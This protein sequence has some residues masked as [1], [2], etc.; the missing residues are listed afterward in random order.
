MERLFQAINGTNKPIISVL[1]EGRPRVLGTL[2]D[3]S[4]ALLQTYLPGP[5]GGQAIGEILFGLTNPSGKLPYTYPKY[6]GDIN[7]NYWRPVSDVWDPLYEF[8]HGLSYSNFS[9]VSE[10]SLSEDNSTLLIPGNVGKEISVN[11]TNHGPLDGMET[12]LMFVQQP[13]RTVTP[14]AKLLKGFKKVNVPIGETVNVKFT[15]DA[16]LFRYTGVD[17]IP[18]DTIDNGLVKVLIGDKEFNFEILNNYE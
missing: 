13:Y 7:L 17:G 12:V 5:W 15:V 1:V 4:D 11:V 6:A 14:P 10:L 18:Q 8:G 2:H 3:H 16:S 9:Y